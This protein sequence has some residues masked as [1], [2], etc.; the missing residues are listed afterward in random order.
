MATDS[1]ANFSPRVMAGSAQRV[2]GDGVV[3][4]TPS[5]GGEF[6]REHETRD[7]RVAFFRASCRSFPGPAVREIVLT[8]RLVCGSIRHTLPR[9]AAGRQV[10]AAL[11]T[12][13]AVRPVPSEPD[14]CS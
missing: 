6:G 7:T 11:A 5:A 3:V 4:R 9:L 10:P 8:P 13:A 2:V 1:P 14:L 12:P